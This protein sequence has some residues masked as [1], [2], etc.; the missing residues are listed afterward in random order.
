MYWS[1]YARRRFAAGFFFSPNRCLK[2]NFVFQ[3]SFCV[4]LL[5]QWSAAYNFWRHQQ[6]L[7][8][9]LQR[10][11]I[12]GRHLLFCSNIILH[13]RHLSLLYSP[14]LLSASCDY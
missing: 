13:L 7:V 4:P 1:P 11:L 12:F 10:C 2:H 14:H 8:A 6:Q 5:G 9:S 3:T